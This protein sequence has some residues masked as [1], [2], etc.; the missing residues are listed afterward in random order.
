MKETLCG[1]DLP[2]SCR[3]RPTA[4]NWQRSSSLFSARDLVSLVSSFELSVARMI[5][6]T[7]FGLSA[8]FL[9]N[10]SL[11]GAVNE[12]RKPDDSED[13]ETEDYKAVKDE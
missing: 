2:V 4:R 1:I 6:Y 11:L 10:H 3:A 5:K 12:H 13:S 9:A 8:G 7:G